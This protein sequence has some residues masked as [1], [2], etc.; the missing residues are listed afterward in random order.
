MFLK[1]FLLVFLDNTLFGQKITYVKKYERVCLRSKF[2]WKS[3]KPSILKRMSPLSL[4]VV[5]NIWINVWA[6]FDYRLNSQKLF[7]ENYRKIS[8]PNY[9]FNPYTYYYHERIISDKGALLNPI[10]SLRKSAWNTWGI[11]LYWLECR[12]CWG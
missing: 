11:V 8:Y 5:I 9:C 2:S 1:T 7:S 4:L 12:V 3:I 10:E 6:S